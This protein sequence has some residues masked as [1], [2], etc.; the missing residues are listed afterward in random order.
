M[1]QSNGPVPAHEQPSSSVS[2]ALSV[3]ATKLSY[4]ELL[5]Q[6]RVNFQRLPE[7]LRAA[8]C[9]PPPQLNTGI[10]LWRQRVEEL[11]G[12]AG[13]DPSSSKW[14][15]LSRVLRLRCTSRGYV[16]AARTIRVGD[17]HPS[18]P[19]QNFAQ[20][21][22]DTEEE[23]WEYERQLGERQESV[24]ASAP[25]GNSYSRHPNLQ[26]DG[27]QE[28]LLEQRKTKVAMA[29]EKV[30]VWQAQMTAEESF[31]PI[32]E[33]LSAEVKEYDDDGRS[34]LTETRSAP[35]L[36]DTKEARGLPKMLART[37][38]ATG[39]PIHVASNSEPVV[40]HEHLPSIGASACGSKSQ[41]QKPSSSH[42]QTSAKIADVSEMVSMVAL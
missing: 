11:V 14:G 13:G 37:N 40:E 10:V 9:S 5:A 27:H 20:Q 26:T 18:S 6:A 22:F 36:Q 32:G 7:E 4:H 1:L 35:V 33:E 15:H 30:I 17:I 28:L 42:A 21:L 31:S 2:S 12:E 41:D 23:W 34:C 24:Q 38:I 25:L 29:K 3:G 19:K 8:S 16:G 39:S